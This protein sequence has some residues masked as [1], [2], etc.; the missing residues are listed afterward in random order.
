MTDAL[1][2]IEQ[3][4][5]VFRSLVEHCANQATT[6]MADI[7][8]AYDRFYWLRER[9]EHE[10]DAGHLSQTEQAAPGNVFGDNKFIASVGRVRGISNHVE[11][12]D[13]E[14][15]DPNNVSFT[16]TPASSALAVFAAPCVKLTDK[17]GQIQHINHLSWLTH[18]VDYITRAMAKAKAS[19]TNAP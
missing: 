5:E 19:R 9:Y 15:L 16:L 12:G 3:E 2:R 13:V 4:F 11:T 18:A 17:Q 6:N 1:E 7:R 10:A 14:S 8:N